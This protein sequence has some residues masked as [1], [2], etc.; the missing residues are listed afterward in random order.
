MEFKTERLIFREMTPAYLADIHQ[1][2]SLP[3]TDEVNTLGIPGTIEVT[4][5]LF[6]VWL[7][8]QNASPRISYIFCIELIESGQ[9]IGLIA[10]NMG[11][12]NYR[13][14][15]VWYKIHPSY[16]AKGYATEG[17]K[18]LLEFGFT[19]LKLHRIEAGCAVKMEHL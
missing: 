18:K 1:L 9:F 2:H 19:D 8:L 10:L 11:K 5:E 4:E 13:I 14:A 6:T 17:L 12:L 15:E 3:Q 7:K 16:W